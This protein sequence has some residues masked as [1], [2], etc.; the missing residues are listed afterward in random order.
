MYCCK[1]CEQHLKK[2]FK[3]VH[4]ADADRN[5]KK[6]AQES[7]QMNETYTINYIIHKYGPSP[8]SDTETE[9]IKTPDEA[10][11]YI[12]YD[13]V[14]DNRLT[15]Q[16]I[17]DYTLDEVYDCVLRECISKI[18]EYNGLDLEKSVDEC[19]EFVRDYYKCMNLSEETERKLLNIVEEMSIDRIKNKRRA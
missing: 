19:K 15:L 18:L 12:L 10:M 5:R 9:E 2:Y 8:Y 17:K 14:C 16:Q 1:T 7:E 11:E 13:M 3:E 4:N 6:D